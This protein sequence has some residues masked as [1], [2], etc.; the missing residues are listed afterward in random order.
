ME[1]LVNDTT[2]KAAAAI[3]LLAMEA[4]APVLDD[5]WDAAHEVHSEK[6]N[7]NASDCAEAFVRALSNLIV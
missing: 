4:N 7:G 2:L 3:I 6:N 5:A 1:A